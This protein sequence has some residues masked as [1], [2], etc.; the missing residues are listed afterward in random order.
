MV[1]SVTIV[2]LTLA[3]QQFG[4]RM[5]R[6]FIRDL[7]VQLSLGAFVATFFYA[8]LVLSS[9]TDTGPHGPFV[10]HLSITVSLAMLLV[11]VL[12]LIYFIHH[13][14]VTIQ[15]PNVIASISK[16]LGKAIEEQFPRHVAVGAVAGPP[17]GEVR[18]RLETEGVEVAADKAGYL[19][20]VRYEELV[21]LAESTDTVIEL[22][23]RP[24]H[25]ITTGLPLARVWPPQQA[26]AVTRVLNRADVPGP[27]R[28]LAQDPVF[29]IDQLVEIAIRALSAAVNDTF[30]ALTCIDWL[31]DGLCKVSE[32]HFPTGVYRDRNGLIRVLAPT[33]DYARIVNRASDKIRQASRA[34][35]AV[36]IRQMDGLTKV[37]WYTGSGEQRRILRAQAERILRASEAEVPEADDRSDVRHRY[38]QFRSVEAYLDGA[39]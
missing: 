39:G 17:L 21:S 31:T 11:D 20:L 19:Q 9:I 5:L 13:V 4:P 33:P 14:A 6:T 38:E 24:G 16:D 15:L 30:T 2:V 18:R 22:S 7:G 1:F 8:V 23:Y 10:P 25:F 28:T 34:M 32:R 36:A 37:L 27:N 35:P 12:V 26:A 3:S 29:P